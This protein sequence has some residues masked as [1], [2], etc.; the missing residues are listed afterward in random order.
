MKDTKNVILISIYYNGKIE[1]K[2]T[3]QD[4]LLR[5]DENWSF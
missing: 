4:I 2:I 3:M 5:C 1:K